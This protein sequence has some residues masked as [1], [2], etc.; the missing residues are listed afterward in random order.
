LI[1]LSAS[2]P[3]V[4]Q[5]AASVPVVRFFAP[6]ARVTTPMPSVVAFACGQKTI[7]PAGS[8][9][10]PQALRQRGGNCR[11]FLRCLPDHCFIWLQ[12]GG[13][14]LDNIGYTPSPLFLAVALQTGAPHVALIRAFFVRQMAELHGLHLAIDDKR[15]TKSPS[16]AQKEY[17]AALVAAHS[18]QG[19]IINDLNDLRGATEGCGEIESDPAMSKIDRFCS[20]ASVQDRAGIADRH[21]VIPPIARKLFHACDHLSRSEGVGPDKNDRISDCPLARICTEV[22]P[23]SSD[24]HALARRRPGKRISIKDATAGSARAFCDAKRLRLPE[25]DDLVLIPTSSMV[26]LARV[27]LLTAERR[28]G[29]TTVD[30]DYHLL[31]TGR[32]AIGFCRV[33]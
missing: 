20:R 25:P 10:R 31:L 13:E 16:E 32:T 30:S 19:G 26:E 27:P 29:G 21:H 5:S 9:A 8:A 12:R 15:G 28:L 18:L 7:A 11:A 2:S 4:Q 3:I 14:T 6:V 1:A 24:Q 22:P 33:K 17:F 23:T